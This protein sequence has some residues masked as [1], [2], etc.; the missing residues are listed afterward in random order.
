MQG[1]KESAQE[2]LHALGGEWS[3]QDRSSD[4]DICLKLLRYHTF[5]L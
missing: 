1:L 5:H 3:S 4:P 2:L